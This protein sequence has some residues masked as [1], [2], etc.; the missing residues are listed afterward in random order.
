MGWVAKFVAANWVEPLNSFANQD[1]INKLI[2]RI[3]EYFSRGG[4]VLGIP[5]NNDTRF[6]F[7]NTAHLE[8]AGIDAPPKTWT[9][10]VAQVK[11]LKERGFVNI[12]RPNIGTGLGFGKFYRFISTVSE[13]DYFNAREKLPSISPLP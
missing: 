10:M 6:F 1:Y 3:G 12:L 2:A 13:G 8:Q 7:Y 4:D 11:M 9:E 5:W